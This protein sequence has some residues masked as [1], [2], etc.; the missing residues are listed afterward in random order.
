MYS[1]GTKY[2]VHDNLNYQSLPLMLHALSLLP[3]DRRLRHIADRPE[4]QHNSPSSLSSQQ[5]LPPIIPSQ[6]TSVQPNVD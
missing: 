6:L 5:C 3:F 4:E 1:A 2:A